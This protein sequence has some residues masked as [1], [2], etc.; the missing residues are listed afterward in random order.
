MIER[1]A[2]KIE[3]GPEIDSC[4]NWT[5]HKDK[6]GYGKFKLNGKTVSSHRLSYELYKGSIP[7][8][9]QIDH[10]CRNRGCC[11]PD[12]L[13][14]VTGKE[15]VRRGDVGKNNQHINKT[16]CIYGHEFNEENT[17]LTKLGSR[18]CRKCHSRRECLRYKLQTAKDNKSRDAI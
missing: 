13:E 3:L 9:L 7:K 6:G 17:Y 11:N 18:D 15:N 8:G 10:L 14:A 5:A 4:W 16:H 1:F 12:H 2:D